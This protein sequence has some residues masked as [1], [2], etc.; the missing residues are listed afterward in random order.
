[1]TKN[2]MIEIEICLTAQTHIY[3]PSAPSV[4]CICIFERF[5]RE[6]RVESPHR[7]RRE[8]TYELA[9]FRTALFGPILKEDLPD[10]MISPNVVK[11][12][13]VTLSSGEKKVRNRSSLLRMM[14]KRTHPV[15]H[16]A[17]AQYY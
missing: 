10:A 5:V 8:Q 1:M 15:L 11:T 16:C 3:S 4:S 12:N 6:T 14:D 13:V 7:T 2:S 9:Q 17:H